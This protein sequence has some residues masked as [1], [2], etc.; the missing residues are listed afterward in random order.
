MGRND[1]PESLAVAL[2]C[3]HKVSIQPWFV[4]FCS[5][6]SLFAHKIKLTVNLQ[7]PSDR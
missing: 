4:M 2:P 7:K 5:M 6:A 3:S 1:H